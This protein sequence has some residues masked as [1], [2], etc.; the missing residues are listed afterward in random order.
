[1]LSSH[2]TVLLSPVFVKGVVSVVQDWAEKL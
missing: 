2:L 1:M